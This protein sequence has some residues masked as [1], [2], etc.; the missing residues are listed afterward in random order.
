MGTQRCV[1]PFFSEQAWATHAVAAVV[2]ALLLVT[3]R[4]E[5]DLVTWL[6]P[7]PDKE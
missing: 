5:W 4:N 6:A 3:I 1:S 7:R 2:T